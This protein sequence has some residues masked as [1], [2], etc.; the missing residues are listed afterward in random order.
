MSDLGDIAK[1]GGKV[2]TGGAALA[3]A[4]SVSVDEEHGE[5]DKVAVCGVPLFKRDGD[6]NPKVFG[7]RFPRWIR[8][9]R[10]K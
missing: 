5:V 4:V 10:G 8:G 2:L 7:I 6:G 9:P 1:K 3:A